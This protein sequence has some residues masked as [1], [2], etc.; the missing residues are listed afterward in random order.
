[1][2]GGTSDPWQ[3]V[4]VKRDNLVEYMRRRMLQSSCAETYAA[5]KQ[6]LQDAPWDSGGE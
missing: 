4:P 3:Y 6:A 1:M 2:N 5:Y